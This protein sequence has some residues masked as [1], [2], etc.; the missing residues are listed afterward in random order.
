MANRAMQSFR[1]LQ[2]IIIISNTLRTLFQDL[3]LAKFYVHHLERIQTNDQIYR[4]FI[5]V[6]VRPFAFFGDHYSLCRL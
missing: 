2:I 5:E 1:R 4:R 3:Y 6:D